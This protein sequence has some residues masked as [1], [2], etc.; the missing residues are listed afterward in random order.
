[1]GVAFHPGNEADDLPH[2]GNSPVSVLASGSDT[3]VSDATLT[4]LR[5]YT[6]PAAGA[7]ISQ[8]NVS[9]GPGKATLELNSTVIDAKRINP[10]Y[11]TEWRFEGPLNL[12][13]ADI[14]DVKIR[15]NS[16]DNSETRDFNAT[17]YGRTN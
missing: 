3:T 1:M 8:I 6:A 2:A 13:G 9:G 15:F 14:L 7:S 17:I 12:A 16:S 11:T 10:S 4:T 5:T